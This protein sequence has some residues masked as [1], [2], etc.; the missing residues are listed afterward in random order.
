MRGT[1]TKMRAVPATIGALSED[2]GVNIETIRYYERIGL[3][4]APPRSAGR[5]R[6]YGESHRQRLVFIRRAR[7]L[8]FSLEEIR[9]LLGLG[10]GRHDLTCGDVRALTQ[11]H[12]EAI[13]DKVR[14]LKRLERT[15]SALAAQCKADIVPDCPILDALNA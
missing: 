6:L 8:G 3:L 9:T 4:P 14:D 15:L 12:I 13:R 5:H 2:T 7:E 1:N 11:H 10:G